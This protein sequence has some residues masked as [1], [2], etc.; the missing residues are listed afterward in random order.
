MEIPDEIET[1]QA[2][3]DMGIMFSILY[4]ALTNNGV[5]RKYAAQIAAAYANGFARNASRN[6]E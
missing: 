3:A 4:H 1:K 6:E 5:P 2:F